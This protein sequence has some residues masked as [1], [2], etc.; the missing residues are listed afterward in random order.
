MIAD[1]LPVVARIPAGPLGSLKCDPPKGNG[2]RQKKSFYWKWR[3]LWMRCFSFPL[4][5]CTFRAICVLVVKCIRRFHLYF[6]CM[7]NAMELWMCGMK[8]KID[9]FSISF[10]LVLLWRIHFWLAEEGTFGQRLIWFVSRWWKTCATFWRHSELKLPTYLRETSWKR[11]LVFEM[12]P[13]F[14]NTQTC[15]NKETMSWCKDFLWRHAFVSF[16]GGL[17]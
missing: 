11:T 7:E 8:W 17:T 15:L 6:L 12:F 4:T 14:S 1:R 3:N 2:R 13:R 5:F 10:S 16:F 9:T